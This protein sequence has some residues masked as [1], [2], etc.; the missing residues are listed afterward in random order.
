MMPPEKP[1]AALMSVSP[2]MPQEHAAMP[3][4]DDCVPVASLASPGEDEQMQTPAV[5]DLVQYQKEGKISRIEGDNAYVTVQSVNGKPVSKEA[6]AKTD[7]PDGTDA[8]F[9]QL[10]SEAAQMKGGLS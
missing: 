8:E 2:T 1:D 4:G 3:S 6:E 10:Q 5:G 7:S 9:S